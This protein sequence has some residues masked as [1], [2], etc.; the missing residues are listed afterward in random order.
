MS[1]D[2]KL[3]LFREV[4][5]QTFPKT[6]VTIL[7][8]DIRDQLRNGFSLYDA[9]TVLSVTLTISFLGLDLCIQLKCTFFF[10]K[11][12]DDK[13][14][15]RCTSKGV[16]WEFTNPTIGYFWWY[17]SF[18]GLIKHILS[19]QMCTMCVIFTW[20]LL[21]QTALEILQKSKQKNDD[22]FY[23]LIYYNVKN[24]LYY[25]FKTNVFHSGFFHNSIRIPR[26]RNGMLND[27]QY[28]L[29]CKGIDCLI[30]DEIKVI[31]GANQAD[32]C[33]CAFDTGGNL[34]VMLK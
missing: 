21:R 6:I 27:K 17:E 26:M 14:Y 30:E 8:F 12:T 33:M 16:R 22:D 23:V 28:S 7:I 4:Q 2:R 15:S 29:E 34:N 5:R 3:F 31:R 20:Y 18:C 19:N 32:K 9:G 10:F 11:F 1:S 24:K 13:K 25:S